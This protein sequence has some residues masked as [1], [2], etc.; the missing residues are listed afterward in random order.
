MDSAL[1]QGGREAGHARVQTMR[2]TANPG[3][4]DKVCTTF[5][6]DVPKLA[7]TVLGENTKPQ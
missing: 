5:P 1:H 6:Q 2:L 4:A 7:D 3:D